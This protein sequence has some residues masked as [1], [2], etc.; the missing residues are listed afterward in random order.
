MLIYISTDYV[1]SGVEGEAPYAVTATPQ[2]PNEYGQLKLEGEKAVGEAFA[3]EQNGKGVVLRVPLLY[4]GEGSSVNGLVE[5]VRKGEEVAVDARA[6]R[7]P[8][9]VADVARVVKGECIYSS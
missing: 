1:F 4:G 7:F 9:N 5:L 8:T 2:P 3:G 6:R